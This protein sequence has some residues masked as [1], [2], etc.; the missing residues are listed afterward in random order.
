MS[1]E[2]PDTQAARVDWVIRAP[3]NEEMRR[4]YDIWAAKYDGDVGSLD[5]YIAPT[6]LTA[7]AAREL[8]SDAHVIDAGAGTGL[9]GASLKEHGFSKLTA[10][11][12]SAGM[13]ELARQKG[14]YQ[15]LHQCDLSQETE[16]PSDM[17]DALVTCGTTTQVPPSSLREYVRLVRPGGKIVFAVVTGTWDENGYGEIQKELEAAGRLKVVS[18][19]EPFQMMPTTEPQFI[20]EIWVMEVM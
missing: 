6:K 18:K 5:D 11:D 20:C 8:D 10:L 14:I 17:A 1:D 3:S 13:L 7:V 15:A 4:R 9:V 16:L 19:D 2:L 12:Y